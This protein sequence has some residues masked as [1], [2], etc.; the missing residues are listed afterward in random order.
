MFQII[1]GCRSSLHSCNT[2][3]AWLEVDCWVSA[4]F[5]S[6]LI[7]NQITLWQKKSNS[8]CSQTAHLF[9]HQQVGNQRQDLSLRNGRFLTANANLLSICGQLEDGHSPRVNSASIYLEHFVSYHFVPSEGDKSHYNV[10]NSFLHIYQINITVNVYPMRDDTICRL[11]WH[12]LSPQN[13]TYQCRKMC[14][15]SPFLF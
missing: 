5:K 10:M 3:F 14:H 1:R 15:N 13:C 4:C 9:R 7:S 6:A 8:Y 12:I 2:V 11:T